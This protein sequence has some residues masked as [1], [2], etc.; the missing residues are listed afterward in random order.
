MIIFGDEPAGLDRLIDVP[1]TE[2]VRAVFNP[3]TRWMTGI[4]VPPQTAYPV[5]WK[6]EVTPAELGLPR[7]AFGDVDALVVRPGLPEQARA[8]Q[9]KRV[10]V[11]ASSFTTGR[12]N[13]LPAL[14]RLVHQANALRD[15]GFAFVWATVV[16]VADMRT[17]VPARG[18]FPS[19]PRNLMDQVYAAFPLDRLH[20]DI[21]VSI[22]EIDQVSDAPAHHRG[23]AGSHML[24]GATFQPQPA[25]L[26]A[27]IEEMFSRTAVELDV[28]ASSA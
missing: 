6:L 15:A 9:F 24:R 10:K 2:L 25:A 13:K 23:G 21:G 5:V 16:V 4:G 19:S 28:I 20:P 22:C 26:T 17:Q 8:V 3:T 27:S 1:E 11:Q 14:T 7:A 18:L 12:V